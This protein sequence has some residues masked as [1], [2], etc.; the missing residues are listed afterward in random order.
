M[1]EA[2]RRMPDAVVEIMDRL[3]EPPITLLHGD[4]RLDNLLFSDVEGPDAVAVLDWQICGR[5]RGPYDVGYF[6]SQSLI[7]EERKGV[8]EDLVRSYHTALLDNGVTGYSYEQCWED[9]R[10]ATLF[11]S[12]YPLNAGAV[13]LVNPRAVEL[14]AS[15]L[16]RSVSAILDLDALELM[17]R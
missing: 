5:G 3:S 13:D 6:L 1:L 17:P 14:F 10:L 15:M 9:Y 4:H 2:A 16:D 11:V 8:E 12:V 7:P